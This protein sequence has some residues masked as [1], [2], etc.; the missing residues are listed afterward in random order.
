[1]SFFS[2]RVGPEP[3]CWFLFSFWQKFF[4]N[5]SSLSCGLSPGYTRSL[6]TSLFQPHI[7]V[8]HV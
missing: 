6:I 4:A 7:L 8:L 1:M 5:T 2:A 3:R